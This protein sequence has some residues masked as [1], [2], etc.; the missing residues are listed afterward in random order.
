MV[1]ETEKDTGERAGVFFPRAAGIA[2]TPIPSQD[3]AAQAR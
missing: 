2:A 1:V 3:A